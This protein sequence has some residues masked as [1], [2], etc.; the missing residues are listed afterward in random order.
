VKFT[1]LQSAG[2]D[3]VLMEASDMQR[4]WSQ[5]AMAICDRHFGIGADGLLLLVPSDIADFGMRI[6]NSD[7]SEAEVCG[8]GLG[9]L[10]R[11]VVDRGL[12]SIEA[13]EIFIETKAGI[14]K[15]RVHKVGGKLVKIQISMGL[16]RLEVKDIPV[17]IKEGDKGLVDIKS[18]LSYSVTV[19]NSNLTLNLVSMGN[20]HAI[21]FY[22]DPVSKFPLTQIGPRVEY[23]EIFTNRIN[24]EVAKVV[25][26]QRIEARV[27]ERGVGETLACGSGACAIAVAAQLR[28]YI[29]TKVDINLPGGI[30]EVEWDRVGEVFL[31]TPAKSVFS[32][33]WLKEER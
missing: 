11:Y 15:A 21:H 22:Q 28:G 13:K 23:L 12:A 8:N 20:P 10:T 27:W 30:L 5:L 26:R 18:M 17:V 29:D 4:D 2:N 7:G 32:G 6:F 16:P 1:K 9:C 19:E 31:G 33:E 14:R 24:F 3:F 25:N